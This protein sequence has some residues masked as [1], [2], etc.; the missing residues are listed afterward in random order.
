MTVYTVIK[1]DAQGRDE[2]SYKGILHQRGDDFVCIDAEFG[3]AD[4][5]LDYI[6]LRRGDFFR[7]W[8][9]TNRWFNIFRVSD[10]ETGRVKGWYCNITRPAEFSDGQI[11][12]DDLCLDVF[13]GTDGSTLLLDEDEFALLQLSP[14]ERSAAWEAVQTIR[15]MVRSKAPPFDEIGSAA[16]N[17]R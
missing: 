8:F 3:C 17:D 13:V 9:F 1:R 16:G 2:L 12:A 4:R 7:E 15:Q 10:V 14:K 11:A 6:L 5:D